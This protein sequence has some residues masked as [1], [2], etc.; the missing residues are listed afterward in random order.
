MWDSIDLYRKEYVW[1][2]VP[3]FLPSSYDL[4]LDITILILNSD[5]NVS[6]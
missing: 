4:N 6:V 5:T 1:K 3:L 2:A